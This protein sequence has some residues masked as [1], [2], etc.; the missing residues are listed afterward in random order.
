[1]SSALSPSKT[2]CISHDAQCNK[3]NNATHPQRM[4][5][6]STAVTDGQYINPTSLVRQSPATESRRMVL[7][8]SI[9]CKNELKMHPVE[10]AATCTS[11]D[12][13]L[14]RPLRHSGYTRHKHPLSPPMSRSSTKIMRR[15]AHTRMVW[16]RV[17]KATSSHAI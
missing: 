2:L 16:K 12:K 7:F 11:S 1:M 6:E 13:P 14:P 9:S 10:R 8:C 3:L 17:T 5:G 4:L 15:I